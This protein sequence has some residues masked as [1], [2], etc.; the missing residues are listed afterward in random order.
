MEKFIKDFNDL[1]DEPTKIMLQKVTEHKIKFDRYK[2]KLIL[3]TWS[4]LFIFLLLFAYMNY[5]IIEPY[6]TNAEKMFVAIVH[7][8]TLFGLFFLLLFLGGTG[9]YLKKKKDKAEKEYH[10][11]RIEIIQKSPLQWKYPFGWDERS[12][13]FRTM[14]NEKDINLYHESK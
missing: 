2:K 14:K 8:S 13:V 12:H 4:S 1:T 6:S 5:F 3:C 10:D 9:S 11:L 7:D